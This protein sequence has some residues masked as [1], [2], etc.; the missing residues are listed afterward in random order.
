M[1]KKYLMPGLVAFFILLAAAFS[2]YYYR[3]SQDFKKP[4]LVYYGG[5]QGSSIR[6]FQ[7]VNQEGDTITEAAMK[8]KIVIVEYFFTTC[9][10]ICPKM[11]ENMAK[12]YESVR[13]DEDVLILSHTVDPKNDTVAAMKAY[14]MKFNADPKRWMFLTGDKE[15]LYNQAYHSYKINTADSSTDIEH[16]FIHS[17]DFVLVDKQGRLRAHKGKDNGI[18][19]Y[20]GT[21]TASVNQL[22]EDIKI[23]KKEG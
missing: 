2:F 12:V 21:D 10:S 18:E 17:P 13:T 4:A 11:N 19:L 5:D 9:K 6:P 1:R 3:V 7:L 22:I 15:T 16:A 20:D 14:S 8:D 23:L